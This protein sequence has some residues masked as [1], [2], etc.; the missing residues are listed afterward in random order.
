MATLPAPDPTYRLIPSRFP[1]IAT[2]ESVSSP[3]DLE[4]VMQLEGWTNDRLVSERLARLPRAEW[5]YGTPNAS[6][7]MAS[8]LHAAP[9]GLRFSGPDLGAWYCSQEINTAILEVSHH[10]RRE[11][12]R[13]GMPEL[14]TQYRTYSATLDGEYE[15][16]RSLRASRPELYAPADYRAGQVFGETIRRTGDGIIYESVRHAGGVNLVAYRPRKIRDVTQRDHF[17]ITVPKAGRIIVRR[18]AA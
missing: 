5:V 15:D 18:L 1:P 6:V 13:S 17:E 2:F 3:D 11:V 10:L 16:V 12:I 4:S 9:S 7:V 8:F 14:R